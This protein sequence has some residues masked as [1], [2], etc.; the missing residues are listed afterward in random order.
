MGKR[1]RTSG[2]DLSRDRI[3]VRGGG[4]RNTA[5]VGHTV[6]QRGIENLSIPEWAWQELPAPGSNRVVGQDEMVISG[7]H[8]LYGGGHCLEHV[9]QLRSDALFEGMPLPSGHT[10]GNRLR[11]LGGAGVAGLAALNRQVLAA[12]TP[13]GRY[14]L[15]I[16]ETFIV[17]KK[18]ES[19]TS[20]QGEPG[21][22]ASVGFLAE[23]DAL[24]AVGLHEGSFRSGT[25]VRDLRDQAVANMPAG[26]VIGRV[27][28]DSAGYQR[29][30]VEWCEE[31][32][33]R[34]VVA[35]RLYGNVKRAAERVENWQPYTDADG[36][37]RW[38]GETS[39]RINGGPEGRLIL[40]RV[41]VAPDPEQ[42]LG[43][44]APAYR[45]RHAYVTNE[46]LAPADVVACYRGRGEAENLIQEFRSGAGVGHLPC[47]LLAANL[48]WLW[49]GALTYNF[50]LVLREQLF[51][52]QRLR[53]QTIWWRL[54]QMAGRVVRTGHQW[55]LR[56]TEGNR[57]LLL[58]W[59]AALAA[60][61]AMPRVTLGQ[62]RWQVAVQGLPAA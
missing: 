35:A 12:N 9:E 38:I 22:M 19:A 8:M 28:S 36:T 11:R 20:Y 32:D 31:H 54:L 25:N 6:V 3:H 30:L 53:M 49:L 24:V 37:A 51:P 10:V 62:R 39:H 56:L 7:M 41:E 29:H 61:R 59:W 26:A 33:A 43:L 55:L 23:S 58:R 21:F 44:D 4:K 14:T 16:D 5:R 42:E 47:A 48:A 18:A 17:A 57:R 13:P 46:S 60:E 45:V 50:H 1:R 52:G 40:I 15:D 27:R 2:F 34:Y